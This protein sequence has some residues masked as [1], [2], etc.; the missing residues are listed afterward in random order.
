MMGWGKA[1]KLLR[2][3]AKTPDLRGGM[4]DII[5]IEIEVD[6]NFAVNLIFDAKKAST[7]HSKKMFY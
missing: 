2:R 3:Q 5:S 1:N 4:R 7:W 6:G